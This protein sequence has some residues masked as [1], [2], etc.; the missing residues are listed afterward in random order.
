MLSFLWVFFYV[1][2]FQ[3]KRNPRP[4]DR[5]TDA[6]KPTNQPTNQPIIK[7]HWI[8]LVF[9]FIFSVTFPSITNQLTQWSITNETRKIMNTQT[10]ERKKNEKKSFFF[11]FKELSICTG[12]LQN[13]NPDINPTI[14][15]LQTH[16]QR[17]MYRLFLVIKRLKTGVLWNDL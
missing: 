11:I 8:K 17:N 2:N 7:L 6:D 3:W 4:I 14:C 9:L 1:Q 12:S 16:K 15:L 13:Y 10:H 5:S